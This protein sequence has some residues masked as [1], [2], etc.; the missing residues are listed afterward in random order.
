MIC[1]SV[2]YPNTPGK[3]FNHDYYAKTHLPLVMNRLKSFG[4]VKCEHDKGLAGGA[5]GSAPPIAAIGRLYFNSLADLQ[6]GFGAHQPEFMADVP[7][8]TDIEPQIL[9]A[10]MV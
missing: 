2:I 8:Y 6:A 10:E 7:N 4:V 9:I 5:P 1:V 3:K